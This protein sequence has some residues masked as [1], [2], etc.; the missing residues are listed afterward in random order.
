[1]LSRLR[2]SISK[3]VRTAA[4][5]SIGIPREDGVLWERRAPFTPAQI[6]K[7]IENNKDVQVYVQPSKQRIFTEEEYENVGAKIQED[8]SH[9]DTIIGV[10]SVPVENLYNNK[11]YIFFSHTIKAQSYTMPLLD[12]CLDKDIRL[13]DYEKIQEHGIGNRLVAF[14]KW[15]GTVGA[16]DIC[17]AAGLRLLAMGFNTPFL[18]ISRAHNYTSVAKFVLG[19]RD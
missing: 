4:S 11:T 19:G 15:A 13:I 10:K 12:T 1:M 17:N 9:C 3:I 2:P 7:F 14:G 5:T 18:N 16:I 6:Q 8:I